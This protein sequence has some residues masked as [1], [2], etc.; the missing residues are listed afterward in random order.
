MRISSSFS[1]IEADSKQ[2]YLWQQDMLAASTTVYV[3]KYKYKMSI[4]KK[5]KSN[6]KE[7]LNF[8]F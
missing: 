7:K 8:D 3:A 6:I 5:Y 1:N 2:K 4:Y